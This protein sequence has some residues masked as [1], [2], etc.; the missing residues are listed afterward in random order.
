[1]TKF[2][3]LSVKNL[4]DGLAIN[5]KFF[6]KNVQFVLIL[7]QIPKVTRPSETSLFG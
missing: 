5:V 7:L 6:F 3:F 1:M 2:Y 4:L